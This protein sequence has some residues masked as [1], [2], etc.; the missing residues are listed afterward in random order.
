M[1][2]TTPPQAPSGPGT[3][4]SGRKKL[5][6]T[7]AVMSGSFL[8]V[9]D[10]SVVNVSMPH[11]MGN[12]G[13]T[14]SSITWVATSYSI[15]EMLMV[16]MAGWWSALVGRKRLYLA[17]FVLFTLGSILA[18]TAQTFTQMLCYRVIQGL[19]G[20]SLVPLSQAILRETYPPEEQ[21]MAMAIF[22]MGVVLAPAMGPILGGW[23]TDH[24]GW[25]WVFY[26]NI[27]VSIVGMVM[28]SVF[29]EDPPYLRRGIARVDWAGI[30][31][32]T[33]GLTVMQI[34]L[35][36]GNEHNWFHSGWITAGAVMTVLMLTALVFWE[37]RARE[38]IINFRVLCN[39]PL[40]I[41]A[42]MGLLFGIA[43]FGTTFSLPQLTQ[44]LLR[45][46]AYEAGLVLLPRAITLFLAMPLVGWLFN[47]VDARLLI[48]VGIG[49]TYLAFH[50]LAHLSLNVGFW[51]LVPIMLI[52]GAGL[53]CMF[54]TLS[55][56]SLSTVRREDM[57]AAT[58]LYT[59]AR[60]V[61]G[62]L[63]YAMVATL[64]ERFS[65]M[66]QAHL[67][68]HISNLNSA[69]ASYY[70]TLVARLGRQTGDPVAAQSQALAL[71]DNL[72][73]RQAAILA[74]NDL[75]WLFGIMFLATLPLLFF[76]PRRHRAQAASKPGQH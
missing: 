48:A 75:A 67:S 2:A 38:P 76:L 29:V 44:R 54:V 13:Q 64:V 46:P 3:T 70:A 31:L 53:P 60:R 65:V 6:I 71:V 22:G 58:S 12:F 24:Y 4:A 45:Y 10:V 36:R 43:L 42:G 47:Y 39:I 5:L 32:L 66:H 37:L 9:M 55:T 7:F 19:G 63:G 8:A 50:Q 41:G 1:R 15:A 35:E 26:I 17:S 30:A 73:H 40:S 20:G 11:M 59:L 28:F 61:G 56:T 16:T 27:P 34:V 74:Y 49:L 68:V 14:L 25:P 52:M 62:N 18:G 51:N 23:L 33:L 72:V 69:Y 21:G 57:T